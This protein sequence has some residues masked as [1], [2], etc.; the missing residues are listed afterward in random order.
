MAQIEVG[1]QRSGASLGDGWIMRFRASN[2]SSRLSPIRILFYSHCLLVVCLSGLAYREVMFEAP[3]A[4]K[5]VYSF[6]LGQL[7]YGVLALL[8]FTF[9]VAIAYK[10]SGRMSAWKGVPLVLVDLVLA[11]MQFS[12]MMLMLPVRY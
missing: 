1:L 8:S 10:C 2:L 6:T 4:F 12:I 5:W 3:A 9:P 7:L 11:F